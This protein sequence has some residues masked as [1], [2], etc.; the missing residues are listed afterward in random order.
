MTKSDWSI[1]RC[2]LLT[3]AAFGLVACSKGGATPWEIGVGGTPTGTGGS[4]S[5]G[6]S[7]ATTHATGGSVGTGGKTT[8]MGGAGGA[9]TVVAGGTDGQMCPPPIQPLITDFTYDPSSTSTS[10]VHFGG[11]GGLAG[12]EYIYPTDGDYPLKSD[13][14]G[15]S[16]HI[17]GN[18][19]TYSGFGLYLDG[20]NR[21]DA[22]AYAGISFK[23]SGVVEQ[24]GGVT[25]VVDTLN[26]S[27]TAAWLN[28][29]GGNV[30]ATA[31]GRCEPPDSAPNQWAQ[32][33]CLTPTQVIP[34]TETPEV[35]TIL[36]SDF[37]GGKPEASVTPSDIIGIHW[38]FPNPPGAGTEYPTPYK[39]DITL[40]DLSFVPK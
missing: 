32:S 11:S 12:G 33:D 8:A 7:T 14:T 21:I 20:C 34:V 28:S 39:V 38:Y 35:Q 2:L 1:A 36:W 5:V 19:G 15:S 17:T 9:N 6:G 29:H 40:D 23:I 30:S 18:V 22:S 37:A 24:E 31:P 25:L 13:V 16:W 10:E 3:L 4:V 26:D 27:I